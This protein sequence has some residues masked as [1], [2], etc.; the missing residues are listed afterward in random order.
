MY[1]GP[2]NGGFAGT[3][4]NKSF[5]TARQLD[6]RLQLRRPCIDVRGGVNYYHNVTRRRRATG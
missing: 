2:A 6:A 3:G 5:S 4:T 1:G